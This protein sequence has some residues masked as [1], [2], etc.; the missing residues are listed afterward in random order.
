MQI[1]AKAD[2]AMRA[3]LVLAAVPEGTSVKGQTI[4]DSQDMP[5]KFVEN[6][7]GDLKRSG[8]VQSQRGSSGGYR[9]G[10]PAHLITVAD[11]VRAVDGPLAEV[12]GRRPETVAYEGAAENL[13]Q[14]WIAA[15]ASLRAVLEHVTLAQIVNDELPANITSIVDTP[16]AWKVH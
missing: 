6:T 14:V 16:D 11:V 8:L 3:L 2:Y 5:A 9:L 7:L 12:R 15:R 13:Q 4:A 1:S 10:R